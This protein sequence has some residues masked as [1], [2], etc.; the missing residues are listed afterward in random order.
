MAD[1]LDDPT[2]GLDALPQQIADILGAEEDVRTVV[3]EHHAQRRFISAGW[4]ANRANAYEI[5]LKIKE[6]SRADCE[7]FQTEQLLHGPFCSLDSDCVLTLIAPAGEDRGRSV[8]LARGRPGA[9]NASMG[10]DQPRRRET[11]GCWR[12][13]VPVA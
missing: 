6:T 11:G 8:D 10:A 2:N 3:A 13:H 1:R 9:G 7:G 12:P 4:G 5:A